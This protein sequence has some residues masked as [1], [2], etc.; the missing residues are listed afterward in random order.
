MTPIRSDEDVAAEL[1][2]IFQE[3]ADFLI[4]T[5]EQPRIVEAST[6]DDSSQSYVVEANP[7]D[8]NG[9]CF[10]DGNLQITLKEII[11]MKEEIKKLQEEIKKLKQWQE[12]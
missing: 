10:K 1:Q 9:L 4:D 11:E 5:A 6:I 3:A 12:V 2:S 8:I 7:I